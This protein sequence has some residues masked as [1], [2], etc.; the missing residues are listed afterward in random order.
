MARKCRSFCKKRHETRRG[1]RLAES[2][3]VTL[4]KVCMSAWVRSSRRGLSRSRRGARG[5]SL[6]ELLVV[7]IIIGIV[8]VLAVPTM[9]AARVDRNAYDDAG[10]IMQLLRAA[11]TH[12]VA[13]GGA[14][15]VSVTSNATVDR[16]TF[17]VYEA[18]ATN[19][20]TG[21]GLA[22]T[23]VSSCKTAVWAPLNAANLNIVSLD[24]LNLNGPM[25]IQNDIETEVLLYKTTGGITANVALA[26]L[27][28]TPLGRT[29]YA[30]G[31]PSFGGAVPMLTPVEFRVQRMQSGQPIGTIRSVLLPPNGLARVFSHV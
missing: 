6:I 13:R 12:A 31:T 17:A 7:V 22:R 26:Y 3:L 9:A 30:T 18:V 16:G 4:A 27:C 24:G 21:V 14:V 19:P 5:F 8:A 2:A 20:G 29:Y 23:P 1:T 10:A 25:E 28:F 15:L 11:R